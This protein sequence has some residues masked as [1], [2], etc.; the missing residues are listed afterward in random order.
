MGCGVRGVALGEAY[1]GVADEASAIYWNP[2]GLGLIKSIQ[3][4]G[5]HTFGLES[6]NYEFLAYVQPIG[7]GTLG[8]GLNYLSMSPIEKLDEYGEP[9]GSFKPYDAAVNLAYGMRIFSIWNAG[10]N[11]KYIQQEID[12]ATAH[13]YAV[14]LGVL[15]RVLDDKLGIGLSVQ[16]IGTEIKFI[17]AGYPL[18]LNIR[19]GVSYQIT[20]SLLMALE[21]GF[22]IDNDP[23]LHVGCEYVFAVMKKLSIA[24]R[25]GY[26]TTTLADLNA[27]SG[28]S[29]GI[30]FDFLGLELDYT[31][32]PYGDLGYTHRISLGMNL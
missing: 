6:I 24:C 20:E 15:G 29:S 25:L 27:L 19:L 16:N 9:N 12:G 3:I 31:W 2:A 10:I 5:M 7:V 30:G 26:K 22:P 28:L 18:P 14:D 17:E 23:S 4:L 11:V 1:S 13:A 8:I 21:G 32:V